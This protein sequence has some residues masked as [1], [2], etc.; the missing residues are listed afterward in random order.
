MIGLCVGLAKKAGLNGNL[1]K[2]V[3][4]PQEVLAE[5]Q[6]QATILSCAELVIMK[7][8]TER[9]R[10]SFGDGLIEKKQSIKF[11]QKT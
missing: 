11:M 9:V 10:L 5:S 2:G 3:T 8:Q 1:L 6:S 4:S 7:A